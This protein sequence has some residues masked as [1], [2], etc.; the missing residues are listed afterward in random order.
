MGTVGWEGAAFYYERRPPNDAPTIEAIQL[1]ALENPSHGF[2]KLY[3][4][5]RTRG[6]G[7]GKSA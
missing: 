6:P 2:D 4:A 3:P 1:Y 7:F 5:L